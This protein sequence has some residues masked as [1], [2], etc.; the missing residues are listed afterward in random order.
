MKLLTG[1]NPST[2]PILIFSIVT[3]PGVKELETETT[4][5]ARIPAHLPAPVIVRAFWCTTFECAQDRVL[6]GKDL[7]QHSSIPFRLA[8]VK[9]KIKVH[10]RIREHLLF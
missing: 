2:N 5:A 4:D 10:S 8:I 6:S 9:D 7:L 1:H 3:Y